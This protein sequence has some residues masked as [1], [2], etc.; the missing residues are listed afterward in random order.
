MGCIM[1]FNQSVIVCLSKYI[2]VNGRASRSEFWWFQ[3]FVV[4]AQLPFGIL[5]NLLNVSSVIYVII[6]VLSYILAGFFFL[7]NV[8]VTSRRLHDINKSGWW[9]I[10]PWGFGVIYYSVALTIG[11]NHIIAL[12]TLLGA[13][14]S[15]LVLLFLLTRRSEVNDN[16]YGVSSIN[17]GIPLD[18]NQTEFMTAGQEI[19]HQ[20][21]KS[22]C[23]RCKTPLNLDFIYCPGCGVDVR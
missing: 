17:N 15:A 8:T 2:K 22:V 1:S 23:T 20:S 19:T 7:P 9:Q 21:D 6:N 14:I 18:T 4:L 13:G 11:E 5:L 16:K 3:L 10:V 12:I